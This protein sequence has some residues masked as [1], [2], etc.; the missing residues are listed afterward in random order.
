MFHIVTKLRTEVLE[1]TI[2]ETSRGREFYGYE[3]HKELL[4]KGVKVEIGRF[5]RVLGNMLKE[6]FLESR[7]E[8]SQIGPKKKMYRLGGKGRRQLDRI[9]LDAIKTVHGFYEDYMLSLPL[10]FNPLDLVCSFLTEGLKSKGTIACVTP[11]YS[12]IVGK[13]V[14]TL[15]GKIKQGRIYLVSPNSTVVNSNLDGLFLSNG[16]YDNI[17]LKE[18]YVDLLIVIDLPRKN[19]KT[20]LREWRRVLAPRGMLAVLAPTV[21]TRRYQDPLTIGEFMEKYEHES[22]EKTEHIGKQRFTVLL[23]NSFNKVGERQFVHMTIFSASGPRL[24]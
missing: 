7:W 4:S 18:C 10:K 5:Y 17:P 1:K 3:V 2:L 8:E 19:L 12:P 14:Q 23:K 24:V 15:H 21:L 16:A 11:V 20:V 22:S 13:M 9:L 6:G